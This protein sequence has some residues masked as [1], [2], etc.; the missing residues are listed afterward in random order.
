M[1]KV[2]H[3]RPAVQWHEGML[4]MPEHFQQSDR[5]VEELLHFHVSR[6]SPFYWGVET[7]TFDPAA[8]LTGKLSISALEAVMPDGTPVVVGASGGEPL[9]ADLQA[10]FQ[11]TQEK[12]FTVYLAVPVYEVGAAQSEKNLSRYLSRESD[13]VFDE[14]TGEGRLRYPALMPNVL[15]LLGEE[16]SGRYSHFPLLKITYASNA[17]E[18]DETFSA[19]SLVVKTGEALG[20]VCLDLAKRI[21]EK[22]AFLSENLKKQTSNTISAEA[23]NAVKALGR[24]L[25]P[26]EAIVRS[27][28]SHPFSVYL[29]L[30][31]LAG[32]ITA[33]H[34]GQ[35]PP[36]FTP[37]H[38]NQMRACFCEVMTYIDRMLCRI[39]EGY[40]VIAFVLEERTFKLPLR[41]AWMND[42]LIFGAKASSGMS[43]KDLVDWINK[44]L[45]ATDTYVA[46]CRDKRILGAPRQILEHYEEMQL[47]P[48]Q[49]SVL[50]SV[51]Y[52]QAFIEASE[53]LQIFNVA[54]SDLL[55]PEEIVM[56]TPKRTRDTYF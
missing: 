35:M 40:N 45:I 49:D 17:F 50:F 43:E 52:D 34:P 10:H 25:L 9:E 33:L 20:E 22:T 5:R 32:Q 12:S 46:P 16:P 55:R 42:H 4:L 56:Y 28:A 13:A 48:A 36:S 2:H 23:E 7:V 27:N 37:Y 26:F 39:Q 44:A 11:K 24:G 51:T 15:L 53:T 31:Q 18:V 1:S 47:L 19:P 38:H 8:L 6:A 3:L 41:H 54:D 29:S 14:N 21:R 30:C